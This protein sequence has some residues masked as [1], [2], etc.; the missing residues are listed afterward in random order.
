MFS[1][2]ADMMQNRKKPAYIIR[3]VCVCAAFILLGSLA[4]YAWIV[5]SIQGQML[6]SPARQRK[7]SLAASDLP[8]SRIVSIRAEDGI[9]LYA[10][11]LPG[12]NQAGV[13]LI[14][15]YQSSSKEMLEA[16]R[17]F[18]RHG[19]SVIVPDLRA[20]GQSGGEVATWGVKEV[21]DLETLR[22]W[23]VQQP[24]INPARV[25]I[26]GNSMGAGLSLL[27]T[28]KTDKIAAV[29]AVSPYDSLENLFSDT[30]SNN[31][32]LPMFPTLFL[33]ELSMTL[34]VGTNLDSISPLHQIS[35]ITPRP[36]FILMGGHDDHLDPQGAY[37]LSHAAGDAPRVWFEPDGGHC[38]MITRWPQKY[39]DRVIGF[40]DAALE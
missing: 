1:W 2:N 18:N 21:G 12:H 31:P 9:P 19:Y 32:S 40:F 16:A 28:A 5:F 11:Y 30:I 29:V 34:R 6:D 37:R 17:L 13:M 4:A 3:L 33:Y 39:E 15:G 23:L 36:V 7:P 25:G 26:L 10:V 22:L 14:H 24:E 38:D 27:Y 20:H 35:R 8:G